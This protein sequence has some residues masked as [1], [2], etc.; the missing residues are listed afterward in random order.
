M[1]GEHPVSCVIFVTLINISYGIPRLKR[2]EVTRE[3][4]RLGVQ[5]DLEDLTVVSMT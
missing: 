1:T 5:W 4:F 2:L 3:G